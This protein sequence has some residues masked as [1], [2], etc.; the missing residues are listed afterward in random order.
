RTI[1]PDPRTTRHPK[2]S[3]ADCF[4]AYPTV[5]G[6]STANADL[7]IQAAERQ[8]A[9]VQAARFSAVCDVWAPMYRQR[10]LGDLFNLTDGAPDS[11]AHQIA[12]ESLRAGWNS[13]LAAHDP[14]R[15]IV[16]IGHSQG[17]AML[18][19][20]LRNEI[21]HQPAIRRQIALSLILGGNLAVAQGRTI[22]GDLHHIPLCTRPGEPG[23]V[24]AFSTFPGPPP[25]GAFFGRPGS[26]VSLLNGDVRTPGLQVACVNPV[27][28]GSH[29][30]LGLHPYFPS[31][32]AHSGASTP[33]TAY[34]GQATA[35][36]RTGGGATWLQIAPTAAGRRNAALL[37]E[38]L[39][40]LW[41]FHDIDVN[42][43]LG[44]L[45]ADVAASV[46]GWHQQH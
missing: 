37:H 43:T 38:R 22:G 4:Y 36:C 24:I 26:G 46:N 13:F 16:L 5:S 11:T 44:D 21:D 34:L 29:A 18:I 15:P 31:A 30:A 42:L 45:V 20:L 27:S 2:P 1:Q 39:G 6:E 17:A 9:L 35:Q 23:C 32:L 19:R 41:G 10:T 40:A 28:P 25:L 3:P 7:R 8:V 14:T 33:W 12:Y